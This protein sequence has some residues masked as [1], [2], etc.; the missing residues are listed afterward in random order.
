MLQKLL[1]KVLPASSG[2]DVNLK[3]LAS[4]ANTGFG[5]GSGLQVW[6]DALSSK[7]ELLF[8]LKQE[9]RV[10]V[11]EIYLCLLWMPAP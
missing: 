10:S 3:L 11:R 6:P 5:F 4:S 1:L 7:L 8:V 2:G 9:I